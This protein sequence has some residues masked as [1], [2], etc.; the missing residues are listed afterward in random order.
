[1]QGSF[2]SPPRKRT[3]RPST[4]LA[5][6]AGTD[7]DS[8]LTPQLDETT[9]RAYRDANE[10]APAPYDW[11]DDE[12][13]NVAQPDTVAPTAP[14]LRFQYKGK[15]FFVLETDIEA[16]LE[17][18]TTGQY[19][20][21][22]TIPSDMSEEALVYPYPRPADRNDVGNIPAETERTQN[23]QFYPAPPDL[24]VCR[25]GVH[26]VLPGQEFLQI[27]RARLRR[28]LEAAQD[29]D[30]RFARRMEGLSNVASSVVWDC[31]DP[32][33]NPAD[34]QAV[35][36]IFLAK[37]LQR[38]FTQV[39]LASRPPVQ[40]IVAEGVRRHR[41]FC[42]AWAKQHHRALTPYVT[43][44]AEVLTNSFFTDMPLN[45]NGQQE[46]M[47]CPEMARLFMRNTETCVEFASCLQYFVSNIDQARGTRNASYKQMNV[48][49]QARNQGMRSFGATLQRVMPRLRPVFQAIKD[50][51]EAQYL[52]VHTVDWHDIL[53]QIP[54]AHQAFDDTAAFGMDTQARAP[55][56]PGAAPWESVSA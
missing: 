28:I 33:Y 48:V 42:K 14:L 32:E 12:G 29:M 31:L 9:E 5:A 4:P 54:H 51:L 27:G 36:D 52:S 47:T 41:A 49:M 24:N 18:L 11:D 45:R 21:P 20:V 1:M 30:L 23:V 38:F 55:L 43:G 56:R 44:P 3:A 40:E 53:G 39:G 13:S 26:Y 7:W 10:Q 8:I 16:P 46:L 2:R 19:L 6:G 25:L 37:Y 35:A 22:Y 15:T 50:T 17:P 34:R